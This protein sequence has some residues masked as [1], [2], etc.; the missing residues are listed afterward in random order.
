M[1]D[2][3]FCFAR[4]THTNWP[5]REIN[6]FINTKLRYGPEN[7]LR[8]FSRKRLALALG[9]AGTLLLAPMSHGVHRGYPQA[10]GHSRIALFF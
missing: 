5:L 4:G 9:Q 2:G 3:P 7:D 1:A 6:H 10:P 8:L